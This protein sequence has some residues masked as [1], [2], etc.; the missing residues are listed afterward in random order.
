MDAGVFNAMVEMAKENV[1]RGRM[2]EIAAMPRFKFLFGE[3]WG[4][5]P[6]ERSFGIMWDKDPCPDE[7]SYIYRRRIILHITFR[8]SLEH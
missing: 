7:G 8:I 3:R 6:Y 2:E 1:M 4:Y 5:T